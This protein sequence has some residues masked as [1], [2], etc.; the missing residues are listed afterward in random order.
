M[1]DFRRCCPFLLTGLLAVS[2][3][4][5]ITLEP[6]EEMPVV[7]QCVLERTTTLLEIQEEFP[8]AP[9][10]QYLDL[11]YAKRPSERDYRKISDAKVQIVSGDSTWNFTWNGERWEGR[12]LPVFSRTYELRIDIPGHEPIRASTKF[13]SRCMLRRCNLGSFPPDK[14]YCGYSYLDEYCRTIDYEG[15]VG[16]VRWRWRPYRG[17]A[18]LW[19]FARQDGENVQR[20]CTS[21]PDVDDFNVCKGSWADFAC[22]RNYEEL[23]SG[24]YRLM[25]DDGSVE[26][27]NSLVDQWKRYAAICNGLPA[28]KDFLRIHHPAA[29]D[30]G[31]SGKLGDELINCKDYWYIP[32]FWDSELPGRVRSYDGTYPGTV[33]YYTEFAKEVPARYAFVVAADYDVTKRDKEN[34]PTMYSDTAF[35]DVWLLSKD[36]DAYL[37]DI[38]NDKGLRED[39]FTTYY[40]MKKTYSNIEGGVGI[41][42]A[43][44]KSKSYVY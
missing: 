41:F 17:E 22:N 16:H 9:E 23:C 6:A 8:V 3:V 2:C 31:Y 20:L 42:G 43:I 15:N 18:F 40:S 38:V 27:G 36:Y 37:R 25:L 24:E 1:N 30:S 39:E 12:L 35:L 4:E 13:P 33:W 28:H 14:N 7:V 11:Y 21:H 26:F 34:V 5:P 19:I 29:F 10:P 32:T 44:Y